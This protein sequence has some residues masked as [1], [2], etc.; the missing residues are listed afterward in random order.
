ML[1]QWGS[2]SLF[3]AVQAVIDPLSAPYIEH[4]IPLTP[5]TN[6]LI[7]LIHL[8]PSQH[9]ERRKEAVNIK[10]SVFSVC[11]GYLLETDPVADDFVHSAGL[12]LCP[13]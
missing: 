2:G 9:R 11:L 8:P 13:L 3:N 5:I 4:T 1:G 10:L 6:T 7:L 12:S